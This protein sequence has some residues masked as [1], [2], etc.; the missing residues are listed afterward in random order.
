MTF[1]TRLAEEAQGLKREWE[2]YLLALSDTHAPWFPLG[3]AVGY[4]LLPF[5]PIPDVIPLISHLDDLIIVPVLVILA[6]RLRPGASWTIAG[7]CR[8]RPVSA[9]GRPVPYWV[10]RARACPR[11]THGRPRPGKTM[12]SRSFVPFGRPRKTL[13]RSHW[14]MPCS[15][16]AWTT[17][18]RRNPCS[19]R[20]IPR[21]LRPRSYPRRVETCRSTGR[22]TTAAMATTS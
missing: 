16:Q 5:D 18:P 7:A 6:L 17:A 15:T 14:Y 11:R 19:D 21:I 2:V 22:V 9:P 13:A 10:T 3:L 4:A 20:C 8:N 12:R 1:R